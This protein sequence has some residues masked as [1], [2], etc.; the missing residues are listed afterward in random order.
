MASVVA[1]C[2]DPPST[3]N[4]PSVP[5]ASSDLGRAEA[6]ASVL[7]DAG[8]AI[9]PPLIDAS[10]SSIL[11]QVL[12]TPG[13]GTNVGGACHSTSGASLQGTGNLLDLSLDPAS[14]YAE[15]LESSTNISGS[16]TDVP[17]VAPGDAGASML[18]IKLI[19]TS[20]H[21]PLY[22]GGMPLT[23]PGSVCP[24]ALAAVRNWIDQG[25]PQ[26]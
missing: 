4:E 7:V 3:P 21:D 26:D 9:C 23:A 14:V 16:A 8:F 18:Y 25:A 10:F 15:L 5:D 12:A 17:R 2:S 11:T 1:G 22:G 20:T 6:E 24:P 19:V 13:C